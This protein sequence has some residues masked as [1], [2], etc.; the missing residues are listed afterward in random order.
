M[1][2]LCLRIAHSFINIEELKN[3]AY[4]I[5]IWDK[6]LLYDDSKSEHGVILSSKLGQQYQCLY[7]DVLSQMEDNRDDE[8][9]KRDV[10]ALLKPIEEGECLKNTFG[11]WTYE[12]CY[13]RHIRQY[14]MEN[15]EVIEESVSILGEYFS[16]FDWKSEK[17]K[18]SDELLSHYHSQ[19]Y[20]NG[21]VCDLT[22]RQR[23]TTVRFKCNFEHGEVDQIVS[24]EEP[25]TCEYILSIS[26]S[27]ICQL[28]HIKVLPA[29]KSIP[30]TC[31]PL[32]PASEFEEYTQEQK[33]KEELLQAESAIPGELLDPTL[34]NWEK[35]LTKIKSSSLIIVGVSNDG[36]IDNI[37]TSIQEVLGADDEAAPPK[38]SENV[39]VQI[40]NS[41]ADFVQVL[42]EFQND[43]ELGLAETQQ[44]IDATTQGVNA[45]AETTEYT[46]EWSPAPATEPADSAV[47]T[48]NALTT[49]RV[50]E[51]STSMSQ[52]D[53]LPDSDKRVNEAVSVS[54]DRDVANSNDRGVEA[55]FSQISAGNDDV[56]SRNSAG[57]HTVDDRN[58]LSN[59][60]YIP[61]TDRTSQTFA[62]SRF[63]DMT[64]VYSPSTSAD[65][66]ASDT[67]IP[68]VKHP[69]PTR[70]EE[71]SP[72]PDQS[73]FDSSTIPADEGDSNIPSVDHTSPI[74]DESTSPAGDTLIESEHTSTKGAAVD[75]SQTSETSPTM[76]IAD[77]DSPLLKQ[78]ALIQAK[79]LEMKAL[80]Q[81][82]QDAGGRP[83]R[84]LE[85]KV[86]NADYY[87]KDG[88]P[89]S[90]RPDK[91]VMAI[92]QNNDNEIQAYTK[93]RRLENSYNFKWTSSKRPK[94][95]L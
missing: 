11:W 3:S 4:E 36:T 71:S 55:E 5:D 74:S 54:L 57:D 39:E 65:V 44:A 6:P 58:I 92:F 38:I 47:P 67:N 16:D 37:V 31:Q 18:T 30:I 32:L 8:T 23:L 49:A 24:L 88:K 79:V 72:S 83:A 43:V 27:R 89:V 78:I 9:A 7:Q 81:A 2:F 51:E 33:V 53:D 50:N 46:T 26:T 62:D 77:K 91:K 52:S 48:S 17:M 68:P 14:H 80:E 41:M 73:H 12:F 93:N 86:I 82:A 95:Q 13:R 63:S 61:T 42:E 75:P 35:W 20:V 64:P 28:E 76:E 85:V 25:A 34:Q 69:P 94:L 60:N 66:D 15:G 22:G 56:A 87:N 70:P 21:T 29:R 84:K 10:S 40:V 45:I 90:L 59:P 1:F 19:L